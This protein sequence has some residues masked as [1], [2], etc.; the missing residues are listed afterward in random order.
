MLHEHENHPWHPRTEGRAEFRF[1]SDDFP[2]SSLVWSAEVYYYITLVLIGWYLHFQQY[3]R[4]NFENYDRY[5]FTCVNSLSCS[6][7]KTHRYKYEWLIVTDA[8]Y[9]FL[10]T[11]IAQLYW[12]VIFIYTTNRHP[13]P[14]PSPTGKVDGGECLG[15]VLLFFNHN[16]MKLPENYACHLHI[17]SLLKLQLLTSFAFLCFFSII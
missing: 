11:R 5:I 16:L 7:E 15:I 6:Y 10:L 2:Q 14:L 1:F 8:I 3:Y 13:S 12:R 9:A 4:W 17:C